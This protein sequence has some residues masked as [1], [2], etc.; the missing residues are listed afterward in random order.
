MDK[1][2]I[3]VLCVAY[4]LINISYCKGDTIVPI[5]RR[6]VIVEV[7]LE[8]AWFRSESECRV[9]FTEI[10]ELDDTELPYFEEDI[11]ELIEVECIEKGD[12]SNDE[13]DNLAKRVASGEGKRYIEIF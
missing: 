7:E 11:E 4:S 6:T 10:G 12:Y 1:L 3:M 13:I 8:G 2:I 5:E 9:K